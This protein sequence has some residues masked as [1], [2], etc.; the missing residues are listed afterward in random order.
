M[1]DK[2][3]KIEDWITDRLKRGKPTFSRQEL[4]VQF[5]HL[6]T[7]TIKNDLTLLIKKSTIYPVFKGFYSIIP[8]GYALWALCLPNFILTI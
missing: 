2:L 4:A 1:K 7:Q 8:V 3:Y 5:S 6:S